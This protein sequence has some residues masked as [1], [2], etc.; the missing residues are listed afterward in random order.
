MHLYLTQNVV[1]VVVSEHYIKAYA[2]RVS[3]GFVQKS[4]L[5]FRGLHFIARKAG[6][7]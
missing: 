2:A 1:C 4:I 7:V 5:F 6:S 3:I